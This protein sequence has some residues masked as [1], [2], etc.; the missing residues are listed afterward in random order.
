LP[1]CWESGRQHQHLCA[2]QRQCLEQ[3]RKAQVVA[4]RAADGDALAVIGDNLAA[5]QHCGAL[6]VA[7]AVRTGDVEHVDL[8]V[9]RDLLALAVEHIGDVRDFAA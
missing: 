7:N 3:L 5:G 8:A 2:A 9:A 6:L 1:V 4:D